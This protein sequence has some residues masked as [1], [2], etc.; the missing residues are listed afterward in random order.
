MK[1]IVSKFLVHE[2]HADKQYWGN[3]AS[4]NVLLANIPGIKGKTDLTPKVMELISTSLPSLS[5]GQTPLQDFLRSSG[6]S[7]TVE[8]ETVTWKLRTKG[9]VFPRA[10]RKLSNSPVPG[11]QA[12]EF[13][14]ALDTN[15]YLEG[16]IIVPTIAKDLEVRVSRDSRSGGLDTIYTVQLSSK[17]LNNYF[18]PELLEPGI[19]WVKTSSAYGEASSGYGSWAFNGVGWLSFESDMSDVGKKA[20]VTNKANELMIRFEPCDEGN[21]KVEDYPDKIITKIEAEFIK[22]NKWEKEMTLLN[23]R[24]SGKNIIDRT[25]GYHVRRGP[26]LDEFMEDGNIF[27]Y[28]LYGG[29]IDMFE[30]YFQAMDFDTTPYTQRN[31]VIRTGQGGISLF[32][33][34]AGKRFLERGILPD[35]NTNISKTSSNATD[36]TA[37][38]LNNVAFLEIAM[39]PF[40][41]IKV[42]HW[43]V[44]DNRE[45]NG[46]I[47][48]PDTGIPMSSYEFYFMDHG[49]TGSS[50]NI[51]LLEK[52][53]STVYT[54][55]CGVW[56][57]AGAINTSAARGAA[58]TPSHGGRYYD[59]L[60]ADTF[61][62]MVHDITKL[63]KFVP[64]YVVY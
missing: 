21:K 1:P 18:P 8:T 9:H 29:S 35:W 12:S 10:T 41:S 62:I 23:G 40:G 55:L 48:H 4:E 16:D 45:L 28:S 34:W 53:N 5:S 14:I 44:L 36:G 38:K 58:F 64:N 54:H 63:A 6:R 17:N 39:D 3:V 13:E 59:L 42:E 43:P 11:I 2:E 20:R 52:D 25:S 22:A 49:G 7:R 47:L 26:G 37:L 57:P 61:G 56:S 46:G 31:R 51:E 32:K 60:Y 24:S 30:D 33:E 19:E 15:I 27:S 50:A